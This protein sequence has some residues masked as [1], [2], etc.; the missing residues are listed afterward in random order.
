[1]PSTVTGGGNLS[2]GD[3]FRLAERYVWRSRAGNGV[4]C[5]LAE[6]ALFEGCNTQVG[7]AHLVG[8][9]TVDRGVHRGPGGE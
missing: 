5:R 7:V 2:D 1:M 6:A 4:D 3:W 8:G 9:R